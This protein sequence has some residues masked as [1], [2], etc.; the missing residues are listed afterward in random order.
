L[1]AWVWWRSRCT[2]RGFPWQLPAGD[3]LVPVEWMA[4][5]MGRSARKLMGSAAWALRAGLK[6]KTEE[7][8]DGI[9]RWIEM[10]ETGFSRWNTSGLI[11]AGIVCALL[12]VL[13]RP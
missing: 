7:S 2:G 11:F 1:S 3:L 13:T 9:T 6:S 8:A 12:Y 10:W 4:E 5:S